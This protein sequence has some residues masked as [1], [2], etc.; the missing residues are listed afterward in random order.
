M[1][2]SIGQA[3]ITSFDTETIT[4]D[5]VSQIVQTNPEVAIAVNTLTEVS[6]EVQSGGWSFNK[7]LSVEVTCDGNGEYKINPNILQIDL[8]PGS[9]ANSG[10]DSIRKDGKLYDKINH[11]FN[12]GANAVLV[13]D[14][15]YFYKWD[16][17][18]VAWQDYI[19]AK[20]TYMFAQRVVGDPQQVSLLQAFSEQCR[21]TAMQYET[22]Q[23]DYSYFGQPRGGNFYVSYQPFKALDRN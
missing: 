10:R 7:E 16:D 12:W 21:A 1:L 18:P 8:S 6:R 11:T 17:L 23:G 13:C 5:E 4:V 2:A 22:E 3:P 19:V 9:F 20:A 15:I 14:V